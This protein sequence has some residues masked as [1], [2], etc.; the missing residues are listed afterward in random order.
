M[1]YLLLA[2]LALSACSKPDLPPPAVEVRTVTV[3]RVVTAAC[4]KASDIPQEPAKVGDK[5]TGDARRD[6]DTVSASAMRLR[7]WGMIAVAML[8]GCA[9]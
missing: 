1:R 9:R 8:R 6:L 3:D 5:L 2:V 4:V 7:A